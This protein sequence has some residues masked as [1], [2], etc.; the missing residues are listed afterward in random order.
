MATTIHEPPQ[1]ASR[2]PD[3][4]NNGND[5]GRIPVPAEGN[6]RA[7]DDRSPETAKT[8]IWVALAAIT[9]SFAALTSALVVRQGSGID[10]QPITLPA[11]LFPN[12]LVLLASSVTLEVARRRLAGHARGIE[13]QTA[14]PMR[15]L[16]ITLALG[17]LFVAGQYIAWLRL[18]A[19]GLYLATNANSSFFYVF[20]GVHA[21]HVLGG[22]AG[23]I[24]VISKLKRSILRRSTF[25]AASQYWHFMG[26]LWL[27]LLLVLWMKL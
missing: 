13:S 27:Y 20:T 17:L 18:K 26:I 5:G 11:I 2:L 4:G 24:Y 7:L 8:G 3:Q 10:W 9:M 15:W 22:L 14:A 21:A 23:L 12:T 19:E 16:L 25:T 1:I 6:L